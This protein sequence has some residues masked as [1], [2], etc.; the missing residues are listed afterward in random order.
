[1]GGEGGEATLHQMSYEAANGLLLDF[2]V[3]LYYL[4]TVINVVILS[5]SCLF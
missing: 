2:R 3:K 1:M 5:L 4:L